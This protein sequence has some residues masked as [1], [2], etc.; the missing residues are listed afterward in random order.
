[1]NTLSPGKCLCE[2]RVNAKPLDGRNID[3][4]DNCRKMTAEEIPD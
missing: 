3:P 1:M 4:E 2:E